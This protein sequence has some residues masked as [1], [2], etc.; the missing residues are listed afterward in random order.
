M[1]IDI[2]KLRITNNTESEQRIKKTAQL[3]EDYL[4][5]ASIVATEL[6]NYKIFFS[7]DGVK[8]KNGEQTKSEQILNF[9]TASSDTLQK[10][11]LEKINPLEGFVFPG[12]TKPFHGVPMENLSGFIDVVDINGNPISS[13]EKHKFVLMIKSPIAKENDIIIPGKIMLLKKEL[14]STEIRTILE[15]EIQNKQLLSTT[16]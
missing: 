9:L 16:I 12:F 11:G 7:G 6:K 5:M 10:E 2:D 8:P 4:I 1:S 14:K 3:G 15:K 13:T